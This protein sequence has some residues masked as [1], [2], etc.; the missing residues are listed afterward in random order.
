[1]IKRY[2]AFIGGT[3]ALF[4]N[5]VA[6]GAQMYQVSLKDDTQVLESAEVNDPSSPVFGLHSPN[7]WRQLPIHFKVDSTLDADQK[8]GLIKAMNTWEM[9]VGKKLFVFEGV[10][11][12]VTGDSF[13][14]LYDSL[15]DNINGHYLDQHWDKTGKPTIVLATTIWD[16]D[17]D[18]VKKILTA[19]IRFNSNYYV[20]GNALRAVADGHR[21]VVD[22]QTLALH[23]L[24]HLLGLAH[25][26]GNIDSQ[27]VM[28]STVYIGEGLT[29]R[30]LSKGDLER[31]QKIYG[32]EGNACDIETTL[33]LINAL[34]RDKNKKKTAQVAH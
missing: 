8:A 5:F 7:G 24:G 31:V 2:I 12:G 4:V 17:P 32:C 9:A 13:S 21:E 11:S 33:S 1:M 27:S 23:E 3:V 18:D 15:N 22:M 26:P 30:K 28:A 34:D 19:D 10:H 16:N 6:C 14:E 20:I 25:I 29:N